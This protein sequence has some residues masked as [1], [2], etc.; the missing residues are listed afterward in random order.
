[1][2]LSPI[3]D[4]TSVTLRQALDGL[5]LRQNAIAANVANLETPDYLSRVVDFEDSLRTAVDSGNP[6]AFAVNEQ[7]ST[8]ATRLNGNNVNIDNEIM[9]GSETL[10]RQRLVIQGLN[11]K[12]AILRTAITGR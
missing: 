4:A 3:S 12:Y 1:V 6:S 10:L 5:Q 7:R 2:S 11:S 8:A 9:L